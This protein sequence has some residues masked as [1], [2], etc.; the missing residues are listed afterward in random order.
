MRTIL[1]WSLTMTGKQNIN[2]LNVAGVASVAAMGLA[3]VM[4]MAS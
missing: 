4:L 1:R 2:W 3:L